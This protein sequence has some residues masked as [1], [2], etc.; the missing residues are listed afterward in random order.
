[1]AHKCISTHKQGQEDDGRGAYK[2]EKKKAQK[3]L[4]KQTNGRRWL[5]NGV[6]Q[7]CTKHDVVLGLVVAI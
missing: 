5:L 4:K 6:V 1:M 3:K 7:C 2:K